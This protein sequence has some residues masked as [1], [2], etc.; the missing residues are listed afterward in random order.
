MPATDIARSLALFVLAGLCEIGGG[1]LIW[2]YWRHGAHW[3]LGVLGA[4]TLVLYGLIPTY[5]PAEF[6]RV[7]A[8]YGG[9][10]VV[11]S[12]VWARVFD[13]VVPDTPDIVGGL[14]CLIGVGIIIYWP[15]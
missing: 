7:Y 5:Q 14:I 6:G 2:Q 11:L 4:V 9:I 12:F 1:W 10:F 3:A 8:A 15:R 13:G